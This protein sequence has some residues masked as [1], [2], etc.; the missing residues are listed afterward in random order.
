MALDDQLE[1]APHESASDDGG[2]DDGAG[3]ESRLQAEVEAG[4]VEAARRAEA[5]ARAAVAA[6]RRRVMLLGSL[7]VVLIGV[8][9]WQIGRMGGN[10]TAT[11]RVAD[12]VPATELRI[13]KELKW[14]AVMPA[15]WEGLDDAA[16]AADA[17]Q[18]MLDRLAPF[19]NG[20]T[21][22]EI[23][24]PDGRVVTACKVQSA[25]QYLQ[26]VTERYRKDA[27]ATEQ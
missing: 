25:D 10:T 22:I 27:A 26:Q 5:E 9:V 15:D 8:A 6:S 12:L 13:E 17:C 2:F 24:G 21:T 7:L 23:T 19:P 18:Q 1:H 14:V 11:D 3:L 16:V 20:L 4:R